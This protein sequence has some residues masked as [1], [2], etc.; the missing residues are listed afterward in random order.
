MELKQ[1][2]DISMTSKEVLL[3]VPYGIETRKVIYSLAA[4]PLLIVPYGIETQECQ[5]KL[6]RQGNF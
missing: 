1:H 3:I 6:S 5:I 2:K 4:E